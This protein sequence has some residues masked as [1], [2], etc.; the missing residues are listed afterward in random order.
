MIRR[1]AYLFAFFAL[2]LSFVYANKYAR[3][4]SDYVI[5]S[6][7]SVWMTASTS[8][9]V[10]LTNTLYTFTLSIVGH[11][12]SVCLAFVMSVLML[13]SKRLGDILFQFSITWQSYPIIAL[14]PIF[15]IIAG[16]GLVTRFLIILTICYFPVFLALFGAVRTPVPEVEYFFKNTGKLSIRTKV[17]IRV[18]SRI[19]ALFSTISGSATLAVV[20]A[21]LAEFLA[22]NEGIGYIIRVA[23]DRHSL[24]RIIVA[25]FFIGMA[26]WLYAA[27]L[28]G[29][30]GLVGRYIYIREG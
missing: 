17:K 12:T 6:L 8:G 22:A 29:I 23:L 13:L 10:F 1:L 21:I 4:L 2:L 3:G 19:H 26:N 16:D 28:K 24:D 20:G 14:A 30:E 7:E 9:T 27:F 25:L 11:L 15:F 5:P 18:L